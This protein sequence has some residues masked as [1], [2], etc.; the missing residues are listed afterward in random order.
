MYE[1]AVTPDGA[2]ADTVGADPCAT[3]LVVDELGPESAS[4][5]AFVSVNDPPPVTLPLKKTVLPLLNAEAA[6]DTPV[7]DSEFAGAAV[8]T[9]ATFDADDEPTL[10]TLSVSCSRYS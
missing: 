8:S 9:I 7:S 10:P 1:P 6:G 4:L 2:A 3:L 5:R